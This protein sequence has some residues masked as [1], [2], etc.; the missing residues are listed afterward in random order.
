M[1][2]YVMVLAVLIL[3]VPPSQGQTYQKPP[4]AVLDVL[5]AP[6]PPSL[7]VSPS[8][9]K[10]L[11]SESTNYLSIA[12]ISQPFLGLAGT[13]FNP[14]T[15]RPQVLSY[16]HSLRI[17]DLESGR[18][19]KILLPDGARI[20][21]PEWSPDGRTI[22]IGNTLEDRY[23]LLLADTESGKVRRVP[24]LALNG[25]LGDPYQWT[26]SRMLLVKTV[27]SDR[28]APPQ[29]PSAPVGPIIQ[30]SAGQSGPVRTLQN[31][32]QNPYDEALFEFYGTSQ[33]AVVDTQTL[34]LKLL[35]KPGLYS[36]ASAS[37]DG[38]FVVVTR[39][40]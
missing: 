11:I 7:S 23:E 21:S 1:A 10:V 16:I 12:E 19:T 2:K 4:K 17:K 30:E 20:S 3:L 35:G 37:P 36:T 9:S 14:K 39:I 31:M 25:V 13:R 38:Q 27:R 24:H 5:N 33:V 22:A 29:P 34:Q 32:L 26:N 8:R 40:L 28:G 18:E 6:L 15:N